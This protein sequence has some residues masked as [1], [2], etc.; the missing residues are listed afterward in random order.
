MKIPSPLQARWGSM[1]RREQ[2]L[3]IT[4]G[5][6]VLAAVFWWLALAPALNTLRLANQ[7]RPLLAAQLQHMQSLQ[8]Q[9]QAIQAQ[10]RP[11]PDEARRLLQA[12]LKSLGS[13][14]QMQVVGERVTVTL[15]GVA[16]DTLAQWLVQARLNARAVP[17][18]ARLGRNAAGTWDGMLVLNLAAR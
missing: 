4:A 1:S 7:Q 2:Q 8:A 15:K 11:E 17:A 13:A 10:P 3:L 9:A 5:V 14:A 18:E 16:P 12:S 6:L